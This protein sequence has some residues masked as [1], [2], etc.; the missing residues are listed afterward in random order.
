[1]TP[2]L[3]KGSVV[4]WGTVTRDAE[5]RT[6]RRGNPF[7]SFGLKYDRHHNEDG[8]KVNEYMNVTVWNDLA[9]L[10][11]DPDIGIAKGDYVLVCGTL[12]EDTYYKEGEDT[13]VPKWKVSADIVL[14][15]TSI[16]QVAGMV[17]NGEAPTAEGDEPEDLPAPKPKREKKKEEP[18]QSSFVDEEDDSEDGLPF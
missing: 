15:M 7:A 2:I 8:Q 13:S 12:E 17:V 6:T 16:F 1:M 3:K 9:N 10:V 14:D 11:G 18:K 4:I 5:I